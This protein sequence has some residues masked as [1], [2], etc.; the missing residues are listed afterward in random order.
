MI[1]VPVVR[2]VL[3][4]PCLSH[5]R[6]VQRQVPGYVSVLQFISK[7][8]HTPVVAQ[9]L[10]PIA[11]QTMEIILLPYTR[12]SMSLLCRSSEFHSCRREETVALPQLQLVEN[13]VAI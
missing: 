9:S 1:D 11:W 7:V 12:W 13:L 8:V 5:G 6:C 2:V 3:V 10:I 4:F